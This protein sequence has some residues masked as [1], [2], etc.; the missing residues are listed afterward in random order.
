MVEVVEGLEPGEVIIT[1]GLR[2]VSEG[3][4]VEVVR[5]EPPAEGGRR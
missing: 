2:L 3:A 5:D 1:H 4:R